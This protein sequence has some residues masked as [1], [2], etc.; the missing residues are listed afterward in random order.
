MSDKRIAANRR[1]ARMST[2]PTSTS[3][4]QRSARNALK[5]G[6]SISTDAAG[7]NVRALAALL[8]PAA[9][10]DHVA[11]LAIEAAR[12]TIDFNRVREAHQDLYA[13]LGSPPILTASPL[14]PAAKSGGLAAIAASFIRELQPATAPPLTIADLAK[15]LDKLARYERRRLSLRER[16][17]GKLAD[18]IAVERLERGPTSRADR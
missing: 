10:S 5:H 18:A 3:G 7:D 17:F 15:N 1:N 9:A 11:A 12:R 14:Q 4:K 2:G 6:L 13:R 8:S 16:A